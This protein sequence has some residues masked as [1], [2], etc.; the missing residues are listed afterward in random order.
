MDDVTR[1]E[2]IEPKRE[3]RRKPRAIRLDETKRQKFVRLVD[4]RVERAI[5][6]IR[7]I[8]KLG[9]NKSRYD[10]GPA[11][12]DKIT[13]ALTEEVSRMAERL[14]RAPRQLSIGFSIEN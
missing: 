6:A 2:I 3:R 9:G 4:P 13:T 5:V 11:D 10:Y 14:S 8:A 1:H 12:V 7:R